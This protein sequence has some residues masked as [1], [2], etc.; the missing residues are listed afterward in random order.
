MIDKPA[1]L[2]GLW[3]RANCLFEQVFLDAL[4]LFMTVVKLYI[5]GVPGK[6]LI[7]RAGLQ[8]A[9]RAVV[10]RLGKC[11]DLSGVSCLIGVSCLGGLVVGCDRCVN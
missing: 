1:L 9:I 6:Q 4:E 5:G 7:A 10:S 3:T 2:P 11:W 8:P